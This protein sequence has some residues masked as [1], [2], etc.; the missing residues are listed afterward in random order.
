M[1]F[2]S[3]EIMPSGF[4]TVQPPVERYLGP[5][6]TVQVDTEVPLEDLEDSEDIYRRTG[7][8]G[9]LAAKVEAGNKPFL[10]MDARDSAHTRDFFIIDEM[11]SL[12]E[13]RG[14]KGVA[15]GEL[16]TIG[17]NH[18]GERF[19]YPGTVSREHFEVAYDGDEL[20]IHNLQPVNET[21]VTAHFKP[22]Y[23]QEN[24]ASIDERTKRARERVR[25]QPYYGE[26]DPVAPYGYYMNHPILGRES[27]SVDG[28]VYLGGTSREAIVVDG[29]SQVLQQVYGDISTELQRQT[30]E[31]DTL[32]ERA[33]L[34]M[35]IH[36]VREVM[37][38]DGPRAEAIGHNFH[39]DRLI[40]LSA[41]VHERAGVCRHQALLSAQLIENLLHEGYMRGSTGVER[42][43]N[44]DMDGTHA[45]AVYKRGGDKEAIVVDPTHSFV[46]TKTE[47][48]KAGRWAYRLSTD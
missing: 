17:R 47:A 46:G 35:V 22:D 24:G 11:C 37:P 1:T 48:E 12:Q 15:A 27:T 3:H 28:G 41:Y 26:S 6:E 38:Y 33:V 30:K 20:S 36:K 8:N 45:W 4:E 31:K 16:V 21:I 29:R 23:L 14:F 32:S 2:P 43:T 5:E 19:N 34:Q 42:N 40:G 25:Q 10:I 18:H 9:R 13:R 7:V 44:E 39:G